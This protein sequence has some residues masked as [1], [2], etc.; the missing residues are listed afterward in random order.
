MAQTYAKLGNCLN[1]LIPLNCDG[2][3]MEGAD[4]IYS[5]STIS[6]EEN[7]ILTEGTS[8][9]DPSGI[10]NRDCVKIEIDPEFDAYELVF[11]TCSLFDIRLDAAFGYSEQMA[12]K[13]GIKALKKQGPSCACSCGEDTCK[14][15]FALVTWSLA[16]CAGVNKV[17][18]DGK[19]VIT[20][21]PKVCPRPNTATRTTNSELNGRE[22]LARVEENPDF[23]QGVQIDGEW[24]LP[25]DEAPFDRCKYE[26]VTNICPP[27]ACECGNCDQSDTTTG[28]AIRRASIT[29]GQR[30]TV[31]ATVSV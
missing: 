16:Y 18:P 4:P 13:C 25:A 22:Y 6:V 28:G 26:Y 10:P 12:S 30:S 27:N 24:V 31:P 1:M 8:V 19:F 21:Y 23:G 7:P 14:P 3:I 9:S 15:C 5:C 20:V 11:A 2:T 29:V 17:H